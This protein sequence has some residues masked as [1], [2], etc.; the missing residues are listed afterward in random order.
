MEV[1]QMA[2]SGFCVGVGEKSASS[3]LSTEELGEGWQ[4]CFLCNYILNPS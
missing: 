2:D 1:L 4:G 3:Y